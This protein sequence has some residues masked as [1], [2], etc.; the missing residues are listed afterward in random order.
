MFLLLL[1][2]IPFFGAVLCWQSERVN[3][4]LPRLVALITMGIT[5]IFT[6]HIWVNSFFLVSRKTSFSK[7]WI[8]EFLVPWIP[9]FGI[10]FHLGIDG[11]SILM[12]FLTSFLGIISVLCSWNEIKERQGLFYFHLIWLLGS[13]LG[14]FLAVDLFLFFF[15]WEIMSVPM[16][17]LVTLWGYRGKYS[18]DRVK[19]ANKFFLYS[20]FSGLIMLIGIISLV[21]S[22]YYVS[23]I[24]TFDYHLLLNT[25]MNAELEFFLMLC[26]FLAFLVKMPIVPFHNWL[27][28]LHA[29]SPTA[30]S[31]D[32]S[33]ILLKTAAYG[34]LRFSISLFPR[35][36][37][38]FSTFAIYLGIF[39]IFYSAW[40]A[41][42]QNDIKRLVAYGSIS[43]MGFI[44]ISIYAH[45][46]I[47]HEGA[48]VQMLAH[49][50]ST[51]ALFVLIGQLYERVHTRDMNKMGGLWLKMKWIP[52]FSLFFS[53]ANI[54]M[55]GTGNFVGEFLILMGLF[56]FSP[57]FSSIS[58]FIFIFS[59]I[60]SLKMIQ[61]TYYGISTNTLK[62]NNMTYREFFI[63]F[64]LMSVLILLGLFPQIVL[65][66]VYLSLY[67]F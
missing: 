15:F 55:P 58:I 30:G 20:Q 17:F 38:S 31:V 16:Y 48:V 64:C 27:P 22:H 36:S 44:L 35:A 37:F 4:Q 62:I 45:N 10:D 6:F 46:R 34:L 61:R 19:V 54:G 13:V 39:T 67:N 52:A 1:I 41:F 2:I 56:N 33:G 51:A 53:I 23:N 57:F 50:V 40:M 65:D 66:T 43:N 24:W 63:I 3:V 32:L 59:S 26:F 25:P 42:S 14:I 21:F 8:F 5:L 12:V 9:R 11:L 29:Y 60:Y 7:S 28:D 47:A 49:G 18:H